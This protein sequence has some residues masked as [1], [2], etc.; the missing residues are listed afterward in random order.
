MTVLLTL[1]LQNIPATRSP[2]DHNLM[3]TIWA[4]SEH[5][6]LVSLISLEFEES[7]AKESHPYT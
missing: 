3:E 4:S 2:T 6:R 1:T 5:V 7:N